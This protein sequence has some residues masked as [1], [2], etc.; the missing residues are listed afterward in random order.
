[1]ANINSYPKTTAKADDLLLGTS[2]PAD[3]TNDDPKTRNFSVSDVNALAPQGTVTSVGI[4]ETGSAL[5]ITNSPVTGSGNINIAGAGSSSQVIL[6]DLSLATLPVNGVTSVALTMPSAFSVSG[7]PVTST[8]TLAVTGAG[9]ASQVVLGNGALAS[10]DTVVGYKTYVA[11]IAQSGTNAPVATVLQNDTGLTFTWTRN[12][13]GVY[14]VG[15]SSSFVVNKTW[16]QITGSNTAPSTS[17]VILKNI[18][19]SVITFENV[20]VSSAALVEN[21]AIA[22]VEIRIYP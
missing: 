9:S 12:A 16:A 11:Q 4:T 17:I 15:A 8:G 14:Q 19:T 13:L 18:T 10:L 6:G 2:V 1:M 20:L 7:S 21:I 22:F 3:N 5:T